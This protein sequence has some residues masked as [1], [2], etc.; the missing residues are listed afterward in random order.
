MKSVFFGVAGFASARKL[1][2]SLGIGSASG[3]GLGLSSVTFFSLVG[4]LAA[5]ATEPEVARHVS[6]VN[7]SATS[8]ELWINGSEHL[9]AAGSG[10]VVPCLPGEAVE[11]QSGPVYQPVIEYVPCGERREVK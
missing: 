1:V 8:L 9:L 4:A 11:L 7:S 10:M 3:L 6:V 2:S 5:Q